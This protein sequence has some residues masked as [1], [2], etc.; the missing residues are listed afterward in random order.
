LKDSDFLAELFSSSD[1]LVDEDELD[2]YLSSTNSGTDVLSFWQG[3]EKIWLKSAGI[4]D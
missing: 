3:K 2:S 1:S 4:S